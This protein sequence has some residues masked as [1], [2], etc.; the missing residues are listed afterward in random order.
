M[1]FEAKPGHGENFTKCVQETKPAMCSTSEDH[2]CRSELVIGINNHVSSSCNT[3]LN[4][5]MHVF[6][7]NFVPLRC[8]VIKYLHA[9][10]NQSE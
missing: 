6:N 1:E 3:K 10:K 8:I 5:C 7:I 9:S 4:A 2:H